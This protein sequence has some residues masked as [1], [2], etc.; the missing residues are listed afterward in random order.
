MTAD[1]CKMTD[2]LPTFPVR[3]P[4]KGTKVWAA[5]LGTAQTVLAVWVRAGE[6]WTAGEQLMAKNSKD[7]C[8]TQLVPKACG[9][10]K[11]VRK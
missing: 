7:T 4:S 10:H 6:A 5:T 8:K 9:G 2:D 11:G 3:M 1:P